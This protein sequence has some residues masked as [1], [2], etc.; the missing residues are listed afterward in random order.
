MPQNHSLSPVLCCN[1][2]YNGEGMDAPSHRVPSV[3]PTPFAPISTHITPSTV[4]KY[5]LQPPCSN[6]D[7]CCSRIEPLGTCKDRC[8]KD[9]AEH[10]PYC[11]HRAP[12][13]THER[14]VAFLIEHFA[15]AFPTWLAP[16]QVQVLTVGE[17]FD[18]YAKAFVLR[19]RKHLVRAELAPSDDTLPKKI[20]EGTVKK[21]P[22][23]IIVG[24][25]EVAEGTVT[26]R[27]YGHRD[28]HTM[29]LDVFEHALLQTISERRLSF[30]L[31]ES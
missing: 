26:L 28:Q 14:F 20:R 25:R 16:L 2:A 10:V 11:I 12:F 22:N 19:L 31:P 1:L 30:A 3:P 5:C 24:E 18:D 29:S 27:R 15:G 7:I 8:A 17:Q 9:G 21:I 13:S 23:L 6:Q 4:L